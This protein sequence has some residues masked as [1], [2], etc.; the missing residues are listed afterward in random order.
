[1]ITDDI[2]AADGTVLLAAGQTIATP[3]DD[4]WHAYTAY[5]TTLMVH[6]LEQREATIARQCGTDVSATTPPAP[7]PAEDEVAA[8]IAGAA[9][10]Q[11][12][13]QRIAFREATVSAP[14]AYAD[15]ERTGM[16]PAQMLPT[17]STPA[18]TARIT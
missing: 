13:A 16:P 7:T 1:V 12:A 4:E 5:R 2:R 3:S 17:G 8:A 6:V 11:P 9:G 14:L 18:A 10:E 15:V